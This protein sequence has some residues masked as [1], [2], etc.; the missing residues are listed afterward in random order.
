MD[1]L[2]FPP[3]IAGF[4]GHGIKS[5]PISEVLQFG[6]PSD[7]VHLS[8]AAGLP[9]DSAPLLL[10]KFN[11]HPLPEADHVR[12]FIE[13]GHA[14]MT[15]FAQ[16]VGLDPSE[17]RKMVYQTP[18][19]KEYVER[20]RKAGLLK[21][22]RPK[23]ESA[24]EDAVDVRRAKEKAVEIQNHIRAFIDGKYTD[25]PGYARDHEIAE[26][27]FEKALA[28]DVDGKQ[29]KDQLKAQGHLRI[30]APKDDE[31]AAVMHEHVKQFVD[32]KDL[33]IGQYA[34]RYGVSDTSLEYYLQRDPYAAPHLAELE[35]LGL[36]SRADPAFAE[37]A[38]KNAERMMEHASAFI[39][40][41]HTI[42]GEYERKMCMQ[43]GSLRYHVLK[44]PKGKKYLKALATAKR[45]NQKSKKATLTPL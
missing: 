24:N 2:C 19:G 9:A 15:R 35:S 14:N 42:L 45:K 25:I 6:M 38:A 16:S 21:I 37:R 22:G 30:G 31:K 39:A 43:R 28:N 26:S 32:Q 34:R 20:L 8:T 11:E 36:L 1:I 12:S 44:H 27:T 3:P 29:Y 17:F 5:V 18:S 33:T 10:L 23:G 4:D 41:E 7:V 40:G 13:G